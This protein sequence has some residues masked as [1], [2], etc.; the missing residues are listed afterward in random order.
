MQFKKTVLIC[1]KTSQNYREEL[2]NGFMCKKEWENDQ[3]EMREP[4]EKATAPDVQQTGLNESGRQKKM[5]KAGRLCLI[6]D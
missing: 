5:V 1:H 4:A 3:K 2:R 6:Y